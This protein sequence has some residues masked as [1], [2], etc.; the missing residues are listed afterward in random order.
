M[1]LNLHESEYTI[2]LDEIIINNYVNKP[3]NFNTFNQKFT[4]IIFSNYIKNFS[5]E[6]SLNKY[7]ITLADMYNPVFNNLIILADNINFGPNY[8]H[9]PD[10]FDKLIDL[11][12]TLTHIIFGYEFNQLVNLPK[13][14]KYLEF[15]YCFNQLINLPDSLEFLSIEQ[16]FNQQLNFNNIIHLTIN[17]PNMH[18]FENLPN[19]L[20]ILVIGDKINVPL[21]NL[22]NGI[23]KIIFD[24]GYQRPIYSRE[25]NNLPNSIEQIELH[26]FYDKKISNIPTNLKKI[27]FSKKYKHKQDFL[28]IPNIEIVT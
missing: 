7:N 13:F 17:S 16:F 26:S 18:L 12:E 22:P 4:K 1:S 2:I 27:K 15:G 20:E 21:D 8:L 9:L 10:S 23:K 19:S 28:T 5:I 25:L 6:H 14:V 11:V 3:I 24:N